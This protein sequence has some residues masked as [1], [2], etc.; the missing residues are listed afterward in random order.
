M[1]EQDLHLQ[2]PY[3]H[4]YEEPKKVSSIKESF[5]IDY[6][7]NE[8]F[9]PDSYLKEFDAT[10]FYNY[11]HR[12]CFRSSISNTPKLDSTEVTSYQ[13]CVSKHQFS[14]KVFSNVVMA[15]RKWKGFLSY[16]NMREYSRKPEEMGTTI[17]TNP[18]IRKN[19]L[20]HL[21]IKENEERGKGI[22]N[23]LS[24]VKTKNPMSFVYQFLLKK[25]SFLSRLDLEEA[26][27]NKDVLA[28]YTR[29]NEKFGSELS[30]ELKAKV[31]IKDWQG[32]GGDDFV[33]E[34]P[35]PEPEPE[36]EPVA[37]SD[38]ESPASEEPVAA[39]DEE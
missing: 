19:Y 14:I 21:L 29:L 33:A 35:E 1:S 26:L 16:I 37:T 31:D 6:V 30:D 4:V 36:A 11:I 34:E 24:S 8:K 23:L 12:E 15:S 5:I 7:D 3:F 18:I 38:D 20:D 39:S 22:E 2:N 10:L 28:E 17:P 27:R 13:N 32:I 9:L 25:K